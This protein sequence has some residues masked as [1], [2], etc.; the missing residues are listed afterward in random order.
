[1]MLNF[2]E[3]ALQKSIVEKVADEILTKDDDISNL[4]SIE[5][6]Q[7]LDKIF[8]DKAQAQIEDAINR[9]IDG[10]FE[11]EYQRVNQWGEPNGP[12]TTIRAQL[13]KTI[14]NYWSEKVDVRTGKVE[15]T[16]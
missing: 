16:Y 4:I 3:E 14:S 7:R 10:S 2:N 1:M 13:E 11:R 6:K 12:K 9:A 8:V 15:K 5:V